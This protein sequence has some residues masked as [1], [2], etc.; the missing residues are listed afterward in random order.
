MQCRAYIWYNSAASPFLYLYTPNLAKLINLE[1]KVKLPPAV[2]A[3]GVSKIIL[4]RF[5]KLKTLRSPAK[6]VSA[7][8]YDYFVN[9]L[10]VDRLVGTSQPI[11]TQNARIIVTKTSLGELYL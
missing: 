10:F 4:V 9:L 8:R 2:G 1:N 11:L 7:R 3:P 5:N 6:Y